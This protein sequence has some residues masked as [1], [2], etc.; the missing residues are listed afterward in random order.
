MAEL[1]DSARL[2]VSEV[3][4][5]AVNATARSGS[6]MGLI[7]IRLLADRTRVIIEVADQAPGVPRLREAG[8]LEESGRGLALVDAVCATWGWQPASGQAGKTVWAELAATP[9]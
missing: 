5:N 2:V 9:P 1:A 4:A 8:D 6:T 7:R 3:V